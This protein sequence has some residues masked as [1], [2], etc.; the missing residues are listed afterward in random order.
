MLYVSAGNAHADRS[1]L[2]KRI[3]NTEFLL[4]IIR[5]AR[6][7]TDYYRLLH[8]CWNIKPHINYTQPTFHSFSLPAI[9]PLLL[10]WFVRNRLSFSAGVCVCWF[11][12]YWMLSKLILH[13]ASLLYRS[14]CMLQLPLSLPT[15]CLL[16]II[17]TLWNYDNLR[18]Q[19][20]YL[21]TNT[22]P[23]SRPHAM[24]QLGI[25]FAAIA[26]FRSVVRSFGWFALL[27]RNR[28][29]SERV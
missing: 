13:S 21:T 26:L 5:L 1:T 9:H 24:R 22:C 15:H 11:V 29:A 17:Y 7:F 27:C 6:P 3:N 10:G 28:N 8:K 23:Y 20:V 16:F 12:V 25:S 14:A 2:S 4:N 19:Y 18:T